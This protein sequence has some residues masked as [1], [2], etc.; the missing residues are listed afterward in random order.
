MGCRCHLTVLS[1]RRPSTPM[2]R[3]S[4]SR[5]RALTAKAEVRADM[6]QNYT[7]SALTVFHH[8]PTLA[9]LYS[10][11]GSQESAC[12]VPF[13]ANV[14]AET[15]CYGKP[16]SFNFLFVEDVSEVSY[17]SGDAIAYFQGDQGHA[18]GPGPHTEGRSRERYVDITIDCALVHRP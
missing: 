4:R 9:R 8:P 12:F 7:D 5:S 10:P 11:A 13:Y 16:A 17:A 1:T 14:L 18:V 3:T 2:T 15:T 6:F